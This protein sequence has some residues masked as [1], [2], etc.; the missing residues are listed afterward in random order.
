MPRSLDL[1]RFIGRSPER[2]SIS[3]IRALHGKWAAIEIYSPEVNPPR[4][5]VALGESP[6][7]CAAALAAQGL[8]PE[9]H[10]YQLLRS[11]L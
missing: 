2:L 3:E 8:D 9:R 5:I 6:A 7:A 11:P 1:S 4:V 10:E